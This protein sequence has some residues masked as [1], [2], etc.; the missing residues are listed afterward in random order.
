M[1][2][3]YGKFGPVTVWLGLVGWKLGWTLVSFYWENVILGENVKNS[4]FP[5]KSHF[6]PTQL[7]QGRMT[8]RPETVALGWVGWTTLD[9]KIF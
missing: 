7:L 2:Q 5:I 6:Q 9:K 3:A 1:S 8:N 4:I